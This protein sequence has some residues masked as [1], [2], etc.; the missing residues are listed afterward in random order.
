MVISE[1]CKSYDPSDGS[2]QPHAAS[3]ESRE[4]TERE[5]FNRWEDDGPG[6]LARAAVPPADV[7][8]KPAWSVLSLR[9][10]LEAAR[11]LGRAEDARRSRAPT[12]AAKGMSA[13]RGTIPPRASTRRAITTEISGTTPDRS[14]V[15]KTVRQKRGRFLSRQ[16]LGGPGVCICE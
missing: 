15:H 5:E 1:T 10:L 9:N 16:Y 4:R 2:E 8:R 13:H 6:P 12:A 14:A 7:P 3:A 11:T